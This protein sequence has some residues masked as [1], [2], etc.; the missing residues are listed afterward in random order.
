MTA[1]LIVFGILVIIFL[2][3]GY[4]ICRAAKKLRPSQKD[5]NIF[6]DDDGNE[7]LI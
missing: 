5:P 2:A 3:L 4:V 7:Y 6:I 1:L